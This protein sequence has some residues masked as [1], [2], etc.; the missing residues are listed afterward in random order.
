[1]CVPER[2]IRE[3]LPN[4]PREKEEIFRAL[5]E[6]VIDYA[7]FMLSPEGKIMTWKNE[8]KGTKHRKS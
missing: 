1:M 3:A 6:G 4:E 5:V 8:Q 2:E 7:I